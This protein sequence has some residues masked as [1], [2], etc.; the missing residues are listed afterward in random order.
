[1]T[2]PIRFRVRPVF[3]G[4]ELLVEV[5]DDH[6]AVDFPNV[7]AI[8]QDALH[9]VQVPHPDGLDDPVVAL[10]QDRYFSYWTYARGHYEIDDDI[11]S[12]FVT[13]TIDNARIVMDIESALL[14]TGKFVKE[15][16][17]FSQFE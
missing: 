9:A 14:S 2:S 5:L 13:A 15:E 6:R 16:V 12:L 7:A 4:S 17:D 11:W 1:M 8:L 3:H 10:S